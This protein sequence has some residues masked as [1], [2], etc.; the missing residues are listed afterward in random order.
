MTV[1]EREIAERS[2]IGSILLDPERCLPAAVNAGVEVDWFAG[3][4]TALEWATLKRLFEER[5]AVDPLTLSARANRLAAEKDSPHGG[6]RLEVADI[7][8]TIDETATE[9]HFEYYL[10]LCRLEAM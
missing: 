8:R 7:E 3:E 4:K 2:L 6:V 1:E 5:A 10:E 9:S